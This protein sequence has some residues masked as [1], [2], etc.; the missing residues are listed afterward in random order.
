MKFWVFLKGFSQ[1]FSPGGA[2]GWAQ[3]PQLSQNSHPSVGSQSGS[4]SHQTWAGGWICSSQFP[5]AWHPQLRKGC[6][7]LKRKM[8]SYFPFSLLLL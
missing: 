7:F 2:P 8:R 5:T 1:P 3:L 4:R 6:S